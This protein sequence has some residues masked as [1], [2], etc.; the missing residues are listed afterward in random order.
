[1]SEPLVLCT[2]LQKSFQSGS[3]T[4]NLL[5]GVDLSMDEGVV[6]SIVGPSGSGKST[7]L[8]ILGSL[9][10]F[11]GGTV[12]VAGHDLGDIPERRLHLFRRTIIGFVFQFHFLLNEFSA[13]ENVALP[14]MLAGMPRQKAQ[15]RAKD[16]LSLMGLAHRADHVPSKLS[17]G[18]RQ[19]VAI[20]RA[21][22][23]APR[24]ILADEPT[25][26]LDPASAASVEEA[27]LSLPTV[28]GTSV[29]LVTHDDRLAG[30][31]GVQYRLHDGL[32]VRLR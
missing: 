23:N 17:G 1:M 32:M 2:S 16:L 13:L 14:A 22:V 12:K 19:R 9:E 24:L 29:I 18:E 27:L 20:A 11:D 4:I 26:N 21:L 31:A 5:R 8:A 15:E 30:R 25:G 3:E 7:F 10:P 6:C 28:S